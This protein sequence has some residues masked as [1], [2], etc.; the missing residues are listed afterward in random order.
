[1]HKRGKRPRIT[2][3]IRGLF[4]LRG[5]GVCLNCAMRL[6]AIILALALAPQ[7]ATPIV[8]DEGASTAGV[9]KGGDPGAVAWF[10][11]DGDGDEDLFVAAIGKDKLF[12]NEGDGRFTKVKGSGLD[13]TGDPSF[14]VAV[15]DY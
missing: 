11:M 2:R 12:R 5:G 15:G 1:M 9:A 8:F 6:A 13:A 10:D 14:G 4:R 3:M 7:G